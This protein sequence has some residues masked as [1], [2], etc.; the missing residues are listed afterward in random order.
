M[1]SSSILCTGPPYSRKHWQIILLIGPHAHKTKQPSQTKLFGQ[2]FYDSSW[3][4]FGVGT[5]A[6]IVSP[7][8]VMASYA[9]RLQFQ[10]INNIAECEA[11]LLGLRKLKAMGVRRAVSKLDSQ[12]IT[13][14]VDKSSK[15]KSSNLEKYPAIKG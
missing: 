13:V 8:K 14:Q 6:V 2:F 3:G 9:I 10:S 11:L 4:S 15:V 5:A 12:V 1:N 7:S